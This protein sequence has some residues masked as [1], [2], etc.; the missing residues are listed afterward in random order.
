MEAIGQVLKEFRKEHGM[1]QKDLSEGICSQSVLSRIENN[2]EIPNIFVIQQLCHRLG[3]TIDQLML[4]FLPEELFLRKYFNKMFMYLRTGKYLE[5]RTTLEYLDER[6]ITHLDKDR[7]LAC[8]FKGVCAYFIDKEPEAALEQIIQGLSIC[9][10]KKYDGYFDSRILLLSFAGK[11]NSVLG[12]VNEAQNYYNQS[13]ELFQTM[14]ADYSERS[15][16]SNLFVNY[17]TF[18]VKHERLDLAEKVVD[19]GLKWNRQQC[20]YYKLRELL[21]LKILMLE[22]RDEFHTVINYRKMLRAIEKLKDL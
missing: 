10:S 1:T 3:I 13:F 8:F 16:L 4:D 6:Q 11:M 22:A 9:V 14:M 18:L 7:Q 19:M 21:E 2:E 20:S 12:R 17:G 15:E 5:I